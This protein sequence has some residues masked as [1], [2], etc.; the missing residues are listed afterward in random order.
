MTPEDA[1]RNILDRIRAISEAKEEVTSIRR[2][3]LT[4]ATDMQ[5]KKQKLDAIAIT[6]DPKFGQN[7]LQNQIDQFRSCVDSG[8]QFT[9]P[10]DGKVSESP[11]I[12]MP[13]NGN[14][15]FSGVIPCL[16]N[17][18]FQYVL[19]TLTGNGCFIWSDG[20]IINKDNLQILNKLYGNY[21]SWKDTWNSESADF[22]RMVKNIIEKES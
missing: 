10:E 21:M 9:E 8:A 17:L 13:S 4:E 6:N 2:G 20:M 11:L 19:K 1:T 3:I 12:Y 16:N 22:E 7:A 18:K 14:L 15:I 5:E